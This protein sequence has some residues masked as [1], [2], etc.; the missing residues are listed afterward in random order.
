MPEDSP[1]HNISFPANEND[2]H[3]KAFF[4]AIQD[5]IIPGSQFKKNETISWTA[6]DGTEFSIQ[7]DRDI[8][9]RVDSK[10]N[11]EDSARKKND[12]NFEHRIHINLMSDTKKLQNSHN[13]VRERTGRITSTWTKENEQTIT[14]HQGLREPDSEDKAKLKHSRFQKIMNDSSDHRKTANSELKILQQLGYARKELLT[15]GA[16][17]HLTMNKIGDQ[18]VDDIVQNER[19]K[20]EKDDKNPNGKLSAAFFIAL[21]QEMNDALIEMHQKGIIHNDIKSANLRV[22]TNPDGTFTILPI[23]FG[24]ALP[25]RVPN[26]ENKEP[27]GIKGTRQFVAPDVAKYYVT[28]N[29]SVNVMLDFGGVV[30]AVTPTLDIFSMGATLYY[31]LM[32]KHLPRNKK[33]HE[34]DLSGLTVEAIQARLEPCTKEQ[35]EYIN[36]LLRGMLSNN[37]DVRFNSQKIETILQLQQE[38]SRITYNQVNQPLQ[39]N[40]E[41]LLYI[42]FENAKNSTP[43]STDVATTLYHFLLLKGSDSP[44]KLFRLEGKK[45][46]ND[47]SIIHTFND[48]K[49]AFSESILQ[50]EGKY[51]LFKKQDDKLLGGSE[52]VKGY[53]LTHE[54]VLDDASKLVQVKSL[55]L[56]KPLIL[57][58]E[59]KSEPLDPKKPPVTGTIQVE[60]INPNV[61]V[62]ETRAIKAKS[63]HIKKRTIMPHSEDFFSELNPIP[64]PQVSPPP[65]GRDV[66]TT[67][68]RADSTSNRPL[69][70]LPSS[71]DK[72][73]KRSERKKQSTTRRNSLTTASKIGLASGTAAG[74]AL[75][76]TG[77]ALLPFMPP[78]GLAVLAVGAIVL[79]ITT[80]SAAAAYQG[81]KRTVPEK[82]VPG[83]NDAAESNEGTPL[84]SVN[85][86]SINN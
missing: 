70:L 76:V 74:T 8:E 47:D 65:F 6:Q 23:D 84:L 14:F 51:Y 29:M 58:I 48:K 72:D 69:P 2:P 86:F 78:L 17:I 40:N 36:L 46:K 66:E 71:L 80:L 38:K 39:N 25:Q 75:L 73:Q 57:K 67:H 9:I 41:P 45:N 10:H 77:G 18:S 24:S 22:K 19:S 3:L 63:L 82:E 54:L 5:K 35:A 55:E 53:L 12:N 61:K 43:L 79:G 13:P 7:F 85:R 60:A 64:D 49:I 1:V 27:I 28:N 20:N 37:P 68:T 50:I 32:E 30:Y 31:I 33:N 56:E 4:T 26:T 81:A 44:E 62:M 11:K 42:N 83:N 16:N 21:I 59:E 15:A 34:A 52:H